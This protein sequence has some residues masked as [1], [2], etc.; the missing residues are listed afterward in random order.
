MGETIIFH[1]TI[2]Y[3][4]NLM[5]CTHKLLKRKACFYFNYTHREGEKESDYY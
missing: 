4:L 5:P 2:L 3:L 1:S